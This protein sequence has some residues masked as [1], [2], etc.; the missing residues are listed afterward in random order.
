MAPVRSM[1]SSASVGLF[2]YG[3]KKCGGC[4]ACIG[5][6]MLI[7]ALLV[8]VL[9]DRVYGSPIATPEGTIP[10]NGSAVIIP[11]NGVM[12]AGKNYDIRIEV[13]VTVA[14]PNIYLG[15]IYVDFYPIKTNTDLSN[16]V[17]WEFGETEINGTY[18]D[19]KTFECATNFV[20]N[21]D[22]SFSVNASGISHIQSATATIKV[23]ENPNRPL[24]KFLSTVGTVM[25][26]PGIIVI[27][28]GACIAG[29]IKATPSSGGA[30]RS[31]PIHISRRK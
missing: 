14:S 17:A 31:A 1:R 3:R 7:P 22:L 18:H 5:C 25:L 9:A 28:I 6:L 24:Y 12:K 23:Y 16:V 15:A 10:L 8:F 4:I 11:V 19:S 2:S 21:A 30:R 27:L 29:A 26:I 13:D 20:A